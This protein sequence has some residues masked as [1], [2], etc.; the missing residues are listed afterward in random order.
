MPANAPAS[1]RN[2][3]LFLPG[4]ATVTVAGVAGLPGTYNFTGP[5]EAFSTNHTLL[6]GSSLVVIGQ[7]DAS[8]I[9]GILGQRDDGFFGYDLAHALG[10]VSGSGFTSSS[11]FF[12]TTGGILHLTGSSGT[13]MLTV[14]GGERP[15]LIQ[16]RGTLSQPP[17]SIGPTGL[18]TGS[19][20][21]V[22]T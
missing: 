20:G 19:I 4:S 18:I 5:I 3:F 22:V 11:G 13:S 8:G 1:P 12:P 21:G 2:P 14:T 17:L 10:P 15:A 6:N 9:T 16:N 7:A